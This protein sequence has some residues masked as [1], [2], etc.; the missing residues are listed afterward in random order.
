MG[1]IYDF[2][3][4]LCEYFMSMLPKYIVVDEI[5]RVVFASDR[6]AKHFAPGYLGG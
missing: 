2:G 4:L 1:H 5:V 3:T 6:K